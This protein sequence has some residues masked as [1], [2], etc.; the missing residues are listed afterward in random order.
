MSLPKRGLQSPIHVRELVQTHKHQCLLSNCFLAAIANIK[1][2]LYRL[3]HSK[4][5][6]MF[7]KA[8]NSS[9]L[10]VCRLVL[11]S[12]FALRILFENCQ[13]KVKHQ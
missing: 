13:P 7:R 11:V 9:V 4:G 2:N 5:N 6:W 10:T 8:M 12:V 3:L 1:I